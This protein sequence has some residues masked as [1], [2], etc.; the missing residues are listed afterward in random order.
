M[1]V[2]IKTTDIQAAVDLLG[3]CGIEQL[4]A[5]IATAIAAERERCALIA[6][7]LNGWGN[8]ATQQS[9]LAK[10]IAKIIRDLEK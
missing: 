10:H 1:P 7:H 6:E 4:P 9:G 3:R 2:A 8:E 5:H